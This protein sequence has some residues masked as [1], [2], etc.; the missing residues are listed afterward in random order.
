MGLCHFLLFHFV[1][2]ANYTSFL[3]K[4][5][6]KLLVNDKTTVSCQT[7]CHPSIISNV[8]N[9]KKELE[10]TVRKKSFQNHLFA[11]RFNLLQVCSSAPTFVF[12]VLLIPSF[13]ALSS[14]FYVSLNLVTDFTV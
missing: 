11:I 12:A 6:E 9:N 7:N 8:K 13:N 3:A 14:Y 4:E 5:L 1:Y 10:K 2:D